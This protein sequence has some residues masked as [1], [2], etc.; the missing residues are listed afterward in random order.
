MSASVAV[1]NAPI[2][3]RHTPG[4]AVEL[5]DLFQELKAVE[6]RANTS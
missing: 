6:S 5:L 4:F 1:V 2:H 3:N